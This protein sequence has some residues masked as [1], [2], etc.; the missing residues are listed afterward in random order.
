MLLALCILGYITSGGKLELK[1][2]K[3]HFQLVGCLFRLVHCFLLAFE[4]AVLQEAFRDSIISGDFKAQ[5]VTSAQ[6][7]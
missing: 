2:S 6:T 5:E 7:F 4:K 3:L 1:T